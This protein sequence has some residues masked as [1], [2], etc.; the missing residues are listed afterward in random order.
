MILKR[1]GYYR[2][3]PHA[4]ETDPSIEEYIGKAIDYKKEIC[5][6]LQKGIVLAAC[7]EVS[8]DVL[9]PEK[10]IAGTPDDMTDGKYIWPGDLAY[11]VMNYDLQLDR[12]FIDHM[13]EHEWAVPDDMEIDFDNLE[14][15]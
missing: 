8:K 4:E 1:Q 14:V 9:H 15:Q 2:E 6:Y 7:G 5:Q 11:Y 3:M 10:G 12:E 13:I